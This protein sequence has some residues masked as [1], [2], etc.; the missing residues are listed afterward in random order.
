MN[1]KR[2]KLSDQQWDD[3]RALIREW[4]I[5]QDMSLKEVHNKLKEQGLDATTHQLETKIKKW[6]FR[7]NID[8]ETWIPIDQ[9][10]TKRKRDGKQSE[11]IFSG[12]RIKPETVRRETDR[13][14]D[15]STLAQLA[16]QRNSSPPPLKDP[17]VAVCTPQ[18]ITMEFEWPTTLPW[19]RFSSRELPKG[20]SAASSDLVSAILP[21]A[22]G[23]EMAHIGV[24]KLA[25]IIGRSMP[26][27]Y[28]QENLQRA[29]NLLSRS[30]KDFV[31]EYVSMFI[32]NVSNNLLDLKQSSEWEKTMGIL[33]ACGIF[34]LD[35]DLG[36]D[37]DPTIDGFTET[38]L[39]ASIYRCLRTVHHGSGGC[40]AETTVKWLVRS[41]YCPKTAAE[42]LW[43]GLGA[44]RVDHTQGSIL[45]LT[46]H[47]LN[48]GASAN[49]LVR[50]QM[51]DQT[52]LEIAL[53]KPWSSD[54]VFN[55]AE[56]LFKH[57]A[58]RNLDRA[59]H[60]AIRRKEK[61]L[62]EM[63]VQHGGDLT[64]GLE[65][66]PRSP[67]H[68]ET[69]LTVAA[70]TGLQQTR[71]IMDLLSSR[72]PSIPVTTFIT[73]DV[74]IAAAAKGH[75]DIIQYLYYN[76]SPV[77]M[78]NEYGITPLHT[79]ARCGHLSTCQ[80]L[81][82]LQVASNRRVT[83][84]F[85]PFH[86]ACYGGHTD[87]VQFFI[88]NGVNVDAAPTFH[89]YLEELLFQDR[90]DM[91]HYPSGEAPLHVLL[92]MLHLRQLNYFH[93]FN[94]NALDC[95]A[96]LIRA[97]AK[98]V[99]GELEM[100]VEHCH[101]ELLAA[102]IAAGAN[103]NGSDWKGRTPLQC[104]LQGF[105]D[106]SNRLYG[107]VSQLLSKGAQ[108]F[109][110]EVDSA[111]NLKQWEVAMLLIEHGGNMTE[112]TCRKELEKA[113]LAGDNVRAARLFDVEPSIYSAGALYAAIVMGN[114][115]WIRRL[116]LNRPAETSEDPFEITAIAA[117]AISGNLVLL[118]ELLTHPPSC[119]T[120]PLPLKRG[121]SD[122]NN[123]VVYSLFE[124]IRSGQYQPGSALSLK[125]IYHGM[126]CG[127]P[128]ALVA[129]SMRSDPLE[130]CSQLLGSGFRADE[131]T[132][133][134]AASYNNTA[135]VQTLV[136]HNQHGDYSYQDFE[137]GSPLACAI[138][139]RNKDMINL[140]LTAGVDVNGRALCVGEPLFTAVKEGDLDIVRYLI[141]AGADVNASDR[142][143]YDLPSMDIRKRHLCNRSPI[144]TAVRWGKTDIIHYLVQ[145]GANVNSPPARWRGATALQLAAINGD[146]GLARYLI[147]KGAQVNAPP[148]RIFG[149][150]VLQGAAEHG[151]LDMLEFLLTEGALTGGRWRRRFIKAVKLAI[152]ERHYVA[153]NI[154]K[155][156]AG[157]SE[158]DEE[159][160]QEVDT[161]Y[162][163]DSEGSELD[164]AETDDAMDSSDEE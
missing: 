76:I 123:Y 2:S 22:L 4:Y 69:S 50:N 40:R 77:I 59:L 117:A 95:A 84:N 11:V 130:A 93:L 73:P 82:P 58:S 138:G 128:L 65:P 26:E 103:L 86:A 163:M 88:T 80:L 142:H 114:N 146:L 25:A 144:Q 126:L 91:L 159:L 72:Y 143:L 44:F 156:S 118:Q 109:G 153:A 63:I 145:A 55:F 92:N 39:D 164:D 23:T 38:L 61:G 51:E 53:Q 90:F 113:I 133:V 85:S 122:D 104:A 102:C 34:R 47:L 139:H 150:T 89:S 43:T 7:K 158:E 155:Q 66:L 30:A 111:V 12:K 54:I 21:E 62:V 96:M 154:L 121:F 45:D 100:A 32:Y 98:L 157:W 141:Q 83:A 41:G 135:F 106:R 13:Y 162:D 46:R 8:K 75:N 5:V 37:R 70:S 27:T 29:Q 31:R 57:G 17:Q 149:R 140:L 20:R 97:G 14:G 49:I 10:I 64:A 112:T 36:K 116:M 52:I 42:T 35:V 148:S 87:V 125:G 48:A 105:S 120:G 107:V 3:Y 161:E 127:S 160:L 24:S 151:R 110:G 19:L 60:F 101:L 131:L 129:S 152:A 33:E 18:P 15:R 9:H 56:L 132:W 78:A 74:L 136:D 147:S 67:L 81:L 1:R 6:G 137:G 16:L 99:G 134:V 115:S 71:H 108:L 124:N 68:K 119:H 79:A 94:P 28:P